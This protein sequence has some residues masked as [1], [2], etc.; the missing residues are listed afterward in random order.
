MLEATELNAKEVFT[1]A[2]AMEEEGKKLYSQTAERAIDPGVRDVF[3]K[4]ASDEEAH[5]DYLQRGKVLFEAG[6]GWSKGIQAPQYLVDEARMRTMPDAGRMQPRAYADIAD[7]IRSGIEGETSTIAFYEECS[8]KACHPKVA[9]MFGQL[10]RWEEEHLFV[11][12][13]WSERLRQQGRA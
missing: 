6:I 2:I 13:M 3:R 8:E 1:A 9:A 12:T 10:A 5:R 4:L 7:A 11:L